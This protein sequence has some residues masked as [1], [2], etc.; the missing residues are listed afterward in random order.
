MTVLG[1]AD[2]DEAQAA[3][4]RSLY[5]SGAEMREHKHAIGYEDFKRVMREGGKLPLA[6]VLRCRLRYFS[7]GAV[8]GG[9][10]FVTEQ[11]AAYRQ[12]T[13]RRKQTEPQPVPALADWGDLVTMRGLRGNAIG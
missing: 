8:L 1:L 4:R 3:Y 12:R 11:L 7:D 9:R 13:G 10:A 2:W 6:S 5:G